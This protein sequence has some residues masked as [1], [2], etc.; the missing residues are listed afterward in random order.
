MSSTSGLETRRRAFT[1]IEVL[2]VIAVIGVL[3]ALLLPAVQA[4]REA[5]RRSQCVNNLKNLA[6]ATHNYAD[7][8]GSYPQ[9]VQFTF[10]MTTASHWVA[11]MPFYEQQ[12]LFNAVNFDWNVVSAANTTLV[13]V[14]LSVLMCPSDSLINGVVEW[15]GSLFGDPVLFYPGLTRYALCS[16]K[17]CT[18]TWFC[19]NPLPDGIRPG[20]NGLFLEQDVIR[21]SQVTD[22]LSQ[23][24]LYSEASLGILSDDER[25]YEGPWWTTGWMAGT[26]CNSFYP[27]NPQRNG[28]SDNWAPDGLYHAYPI[29]VSSEHSGGANAAMA[30]GSVRFI[31]N[32]INTWTIDPRTGLPIGW[33]RDPNSSYGNLI[34]AGP[35]AQV[36]VWQRITTRNWG[37][38]ISAD[39]Y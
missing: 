8:F 28:V 16:Y 3:I 35:Q 34:P 1:L 21:P 31:K 18:G 4:A 24:V 10:N 19:N 39:A 23:T 33:K 11:L 32:T 2:V 5:A 22:G 7:A 36:G 30:D 27:V 12:P 15:D 17:G 29:A 37:E 38:V 13:G 9:G 6:L 14:R 25:L 26:L 20:G